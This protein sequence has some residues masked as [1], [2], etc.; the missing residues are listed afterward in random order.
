MSFCQ[1]RGHKAGTPSK[2]DLLY[3]V[4]YVYP[5][6]N[7]TLFYQICGEC[8]KYFNGDLTML[9]LMSWAN[10]YFRAYSG[11]VLHAVFLLSQRD[12]IVP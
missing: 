8:V 4:P 6:K 9:I 5:D 11:S 2:Q 1:F 3:V 12:R 7:A 10:E